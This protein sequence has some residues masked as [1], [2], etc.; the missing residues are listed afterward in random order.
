VSF[1]PRSFRSF[2]FGAWALLIT[3]VHQSA[4]ADI[5]G[6]G[7]A[8]WLRRNGEA[9]LLAILIPLF[10]ELFVSKTDPYRPTDAVAGRSAP[11]LQQFG[12]WI[13]AMLVLTVIL[14]N[15]A[16]AGAFGLPTSITTYGEAFLATAVVSIYL[17]WSRGLLQE[18]ATGAPVVSGI[19]RAGYYLA[20]GGLT[21]LFHQS[22]VA[23]GLPASFV[24]WWTLNAE[25]YGA[26]LVV[27]LW[28]DIV[29]GRP[30]PK[31]AW[32]AALWVAILALI[33][34][35]FG[36]GEGET[37]LIGSGMADLSTWIG[38]TT[39]AFIAALVIGFYF[40]VWRRL[41]AMPWDRQ[42]GAIAESIRLNNGRA[43]RSS[44]PTTVPEM[45]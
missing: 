41:P 20:V 33:P 8:G 34:G 5:V 31:A 38:R 7:P 19:A 25:A 40:M 10:W 39:E 3:L 28:F 12:A 26:M 1:T 14:Q 23:D 15:S 30:W 43:N 13:G 17:A 9:Y 29:A 22:F 21:A 4:V 24:E 6:N 2:Y 45:K 11:S 37:A 42:D 27:P 44:E 35:V 16:I 18:A 36:A 32:A